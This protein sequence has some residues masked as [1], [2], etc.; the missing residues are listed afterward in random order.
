MVAAFYERYFELR[1][2]K[3]QIKIELGALED[4]FHGKSSGYDPLV[5]FLNNPILINENKT[6][7][8]LRNIEFRG[9]D[10]QVFLIDTG[11]ARQTKGFVN[12][13]MKDLDNRNYR[14]QFEEKYIEPSNRAIKTLLQN[15]NDSFFK[16]VKEI[17]T[18]QFDN[19]KSLIPKNIISLYK[20]SLQ[21]DDFT[22][23]LCG[24][25]GGGYFLGFT[26]NMDDVKKQFDQNN[27][28]ILLV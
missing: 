20:D 2:N 25:G 6:F 16:S 10:V 21:S 17:S 26:R 8:E 28:R 15:D 18:Y 22:L 3:D 11:F 1:K 5:S 19:W 9:S 14:Q 23:K 12:S 7:E 13:F 24:A 27:I 4:F